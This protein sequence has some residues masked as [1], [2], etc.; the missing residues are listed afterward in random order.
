MDAAGLIQATRSLGRAG[1]TA[2]GPSAERCLPRLRS[3][4]VRGLTV[5]IFHEITDTPS[6]FQRRALISTSPALFARQIRWISERFDVIAPTELEQLGGAA[7]PPPNAALITFDDAWAG[8]FRIGLQILNSLEVPS[9]CFIN[10]APVAGAPDL[11][12]VRLYERLYGA[13]AAGNLDGEHSLTTATS[14]LKTIAE[15]YQ[16]DPQF[17]AFQGATATAQDLAGAARSGRVWFGQHLHHHWD[18]ALTDDQLFETSLRSN[19][20]ALEAYANRLP[21]FAPPFGRVTASLLPV[22]Q[23]AGM[24]AVFIAAG[25]QNRTAEAPVLD[26]VTL[27][28]DRVA[29]AE[30]WYQTHRRRLFGPLARR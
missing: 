6:Q 22:A 23:R 18:L 25:G 1:G 27:P 12:A 17:A 13:G 14:A 9:L 10:T 30:W 24:K 29:P 26:R 4:L 7:P 19:A 20:R 15:R 8:V 11:G 2:L 16:G 21:V 3:R 28:T 5:F